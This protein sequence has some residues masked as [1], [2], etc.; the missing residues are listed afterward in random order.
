MLPK[1]SASQAWGLKCDVGFDFIIV[2]IL[3]FIYTVYVIVNFVLYTC[4][5]ATV[6]EVRALCG[7]GGTSRGGALSVKR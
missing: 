6:E 1:L 2:I 3:Y 5:R 7:R 4:V